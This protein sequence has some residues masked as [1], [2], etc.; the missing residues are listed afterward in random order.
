MDDFTES[1]PLPLEFFLGDR[2]VT[3]KKAE[4]LDPNSDRMVYRLELTDSSSLPSIVILKKQKPGWEDQFNNEK[5]AYN[6]LSRL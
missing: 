6:L 3:A 5:K 2:C 1:L 4:L